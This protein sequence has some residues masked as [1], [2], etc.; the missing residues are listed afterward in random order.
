MKVRFGLL[1]TLSTATLAV[2]FLIQPG[3]VRADFPGQ[4][5]NNQGVTFP[6][7]VQLGNIFVQGQ[8]VQIPVSI[9]KGSSA[10]WVVTDFQDQKVANGT[11]AVT[12]GKITIEPAATATG[13]GIF[14]VK[15]TATDNGA[16]TGEGTTTY[17][18]VP[19]LDN[20]K[21]ADA[22]FGVASH[23]GK[24]MTTDLAP[25]LAKAGVASVRDSMDWSWIETKPGVFDFTVHNFTDRVAELDKNHINTVFTI[26]F[27]NSLH[28]DDPKIQSYCAAP[29][30]QSQYDA[31]TRLCLEHL[32]QFGA[33]IKTVEI[34]NEYNGS[35]C[36]GAAESD[37][38][39][40]YT[41]MLKDVY[42][43]V[44]QERPDVQVLGAALNGIPLPYAE[45]LF[46]AG[47]LDYMDGIVIH[48]Y[49]GSATS[50]QAGVRALVDLMKQYNNGVAKPIWV[51]EMGDWTDKTLVR[52]EEGTH[53]MKMYTMFQ[54][55][56]EI[57]RGYWYLARDYPDEGFP[58]MGLVHT[59][60]SPMGKY[61]PTAV[62][63]A[64]ATMANQLFN[65][66]PLP[67]LP[68]D[69]RT[70]LYHFERNGQ[71][72]WVCWSEV[73][74][75]SLIFK[76]KSPLRQVNFIGGENKLTPDGNGEVSL[77][78]DGTPY[79][80]IADKAADV[81]SVK[82]SP[83]PDTIVADAETGFSGEQGKN[84]WSYDMY[85]SNGD[86]SAHYEPDKAQP[87][88]WGVIAGDWGY[89]WNGPG[90]WYNITA[91]GSQSSSSGGNQLWTVRRW[92][93]NTD[94]DLRL[95]GVVSRPDPNGDGVGF[96]IFVDGQQVYSKMIPPKGDDKVDQ[97]ITVKSGSQ[98]DFVITPGPGNDTSYDAT[99]FKMT[100]STVTK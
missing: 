52:N 89:S 97:K 48:N 62:Y 27:G 28:Y 49:G 57:A 29:H 94:G 40:Y 21:M 39:K 16:S 5:A 77:P 34:W 70:N 71:G 17:A 36:R 30:T 66:K 85:T 35:F 51:T 32:K 68:V 75:T 47:A 88:T 87:M 91:D 76:T 9:D 53:L 13:L 41:E 92:T 65:A 96:K 69:S 72:I 58:T 60:D 73:G 78:L 4:P 55:Q 63:A 93:S 84:G 83:R 38:T 14:V 79:Y 90:Q 2:L 99:S 33:G 56:P 46:K 100:V 8:K 74:T 6:D 7:Q 67:Q 64:Y 25:L 12:G 45:K 42:T 19:P 43:A 86:G 18:V 82:E 98:V 59:P 3:L 1:S 80:I 23:F 10:D 24:F 95:A 81:A 15:V 11:T 26:C 31:Y 50:I 22:R 44:K 61:T 54:N 20:S 37:R